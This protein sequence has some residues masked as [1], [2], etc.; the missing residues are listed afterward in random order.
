MRAEQ[1]PFLQARA[2][3]AGYSGREVLR[4]IDLEV[5]RGEVLSVA[6]PNGSGKSTLLRAVTGLLPLLEGEVRIDGTLLVDLAA[7]ERARRCA[8]QPQVEAPMFDYTV[9]QFVLLGRHP[10]RPALAVAT[11]QDGHAV[12]R[13]M[14]QTEM[15]GFEQRSIR[16]LSSGEW[17]RTLLARALAQEAPLLL[18]DEPAAHLDP[19]HRF[20]VHTL[21]RSLAREQNRA[22]LCVSHDLNLAAEFSDRMI[23]MTEGRVQAAG[24]PQ[25]VL[26]EPNLR[27]VFRCEALRVGPNPFTGRPG[28]FF[29]P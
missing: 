9:G 7:K 23:I 10:H 21:L 2:V 5:R 27:E 24:T 26:T 17:Q 11:A 4:G 6:G 28:T 18:L 12:S 15:T 8:V 16:S 1:E 25:E 13:A 22:V 14:E 20:A 3:R 19:G 29:A